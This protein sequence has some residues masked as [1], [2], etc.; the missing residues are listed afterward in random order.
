MGHPKVNPLP[1]QSCTAGQVSGANRT[2]HRS[3]LSSGT[4]QFVSS[5]SRLL[6][7]LRQR[8]TTYRSFL[9]RKAETGSALGVHCAT[10]PTTARAMQSKLVSNLEALEY[11]IDQAA[12][13][14]AKGN[15]VPMRVRLVRFIYNH[16]FSSNPLSSLRSETPRWTLIRKLCG[17]LLRQPGSSPGLLRSPSPAE[18]H[19]ALLFDCAFETRTQLKTVRNL[20]FDLVRFR[21]CQ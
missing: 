7:P 12:I 21:P 2:S 5:A 14:L 18:I 15:P 1:P 19:L 20:Q 11:A 6:R 3:E 4:L 10:V 16:F 13:R 17:R 9:R 8:G